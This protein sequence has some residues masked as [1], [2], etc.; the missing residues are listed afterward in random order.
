VGK[1]RFYRFRSRHHRQCRSNNGDDS[2]SNISIVER[3]K[4]SS[5]HVLFD[6][7]PPTE[8]A[9]TINNIYID[10]SYEFICRKRKQ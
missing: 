4:H 7:M 8:I 10:S 9:E 5:W 3:K 1:K 2:V 6:N